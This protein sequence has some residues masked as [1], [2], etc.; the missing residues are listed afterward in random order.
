MQEEKKIAETVQPAN[1]EALEQELQALTEAQKE[2]ETARIDRATEKAVEE[3][4]TAEQE[5]S[6]Q[7]NEQA[8]QIDR[9]E[10]I[11]LDNQALYAEARGDRGGIGQAQYGSIR[12]QAAASRYALGQA[13]TKLA[14]DTAKQI[15]DLRAQGEFEKADALL[16]LT[17]QS[18]QELQ[19]LRRWAQEYNLDAAE[20]NAALRQ[21]EAEYAL[22]QEKLGLSREEA[23]R[24]AQDELRDA[25]WKLLEAGILPTDAQ[26]AAMG[27][28]KQQAEAHLN[29]APKVIYVTRQEEEEEE[30]PA[31]RQPAVVPK[32]QTP[33]AKKPI[34]GA[35]NQTK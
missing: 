4:Q 21:W 12:N 5:L 35:T 19:E 24:K 31:V 9:N 15:A 10:A 33:P 25:G 29:A 16:T 26:L 22:Q 30:E 7:F 27:L 8:R 20:T 14:S 13:R 32:P 17:Q 6:E 28:T 34:T 18:L 1:I 23:A 2:Q 11:S 3:L